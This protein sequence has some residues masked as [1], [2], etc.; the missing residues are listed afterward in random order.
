MMD[1]GVL[2]TG[3]SLLKVG[4]DLDG[5]IQIL[6][7]IGFPVLVLVR[8]CQQGMTSSTSSSTFSGSLATSGLRQDLLWMLKT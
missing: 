3:K 1:F 6:G 5:V 7:G 4:R 8:A 2:I